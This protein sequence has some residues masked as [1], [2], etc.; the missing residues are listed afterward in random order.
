[1]LPTLEELGIGFVPFSPLGRGFLTGT[2]DESTTFDSDDI[3]TSLP[4]FAAEARKANQALVDLLGAIA[5][6]QGR[7]AGADR[8]GVAA[9][10]E[11]VDR[12]DPRH[13]EAASASR[14]TSA[15]PTSS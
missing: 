14:R 9:R 13:H 7:D 5:A 15:R 3:R 1:M 4:R 6:A 12:A 2:I 8:A 10:A 11:A